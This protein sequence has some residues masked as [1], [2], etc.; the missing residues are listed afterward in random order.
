MM[1][2]SNSSAVSTSNTIAVVQF[3]LG[4]ADSSP[5]ATGQSISFNM[6][7]SSTTYPGFIYTFKVG[8]STTAL[9]FDDVYYV[10]LFD[11]STASSVLYTT[12]YTL[13]VGR[14]WRL[15]L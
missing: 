15:V 12:G 8:Y 13:H 7:W 11:S 4:A 6:S 14:V 3:T 9:Y 1:E 2:V 5:T 10:R